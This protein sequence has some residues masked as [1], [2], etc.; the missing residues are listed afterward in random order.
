MWVGTNGGVS[1]Y[2]GANWTTFTTRQSLVNNG[3][4]AILQDHRGNFW[5]GTDNGVSRFDPPSTPG[6]AG[7][8]TTFNTH[9]GLVYNTVRTIIQDRDGTLWFGTYGGGVSRFDG[10]QW[11]SFTR[12]QDPAD[13]WTQ[14]IFQDQAGHLWFGS[15][16]GGVLRYDGQTLQTLIRADGL[17]GNGIKAIFQD[18]DGALWFGTGDGVTRYRPP[19]PASPPVLIEAV[20]A[21]D[22]YE[23][24][25]DVA[26]SSGAGLV[27]FEF[28]GISFKTRPEAMVYRYRLKGHDANWQT[29]RARRVEYRNL[30]RGG[31]V[32]EVQAVDRD[33]NYSAM[34]ASVNLQMHLP[35]ERIGWIAALAIALALVAW[36]TGRVIHR[37][38]RLS[39]ANHDLES[40]NQSLS[41]VN[42]DLSHVNQALEE[43]TFNLA[44]A[45]DDL[46]S[47][48]RQ[49]KE[50]DRL[51]SQFLANMSHELRTPMNAI[52]GFTRIVLRRSGD[53]LPERQKDN[54]DKVQQSAANLLS[55]INDILDL[56]KIEAG[57]LEIQPAP[58]DVQK[59]LTGCCASLSPLVKPDVD[60]TCEVAPDVGQAHTDEARVRQ[61]MT[62]LVNN[63]LKFTDTGQVR[64]RA[65]K[66]PARRSGDPDLLVLSV[67]DT[68]IGM[69][70]EALS[71]IFEEFR[72]VDGATTRRYGG[73]GLGLSIT[74]RLADLLGGDVD[75]ESQE[76]KGSTFT[77]R[78]PLVYQPS[79]DAPQISADTGDRPIRTPEP[80][81]TPQSGT[82]ADAPLIL[83]IDNDPDVAAL[84]RQELGEAG[85]R[86]VGVSSTLEGF[87]KA[88]DL[89]PFAIA[90][91]ILM[92]DKDSWAAI[93]LLKADPSTRDIP[94][95]IISVSDNKALAARLGVADYLVKPV[96][97]GSLLAAMGRLR[98]KDLRVIHIIDD[99]P[100]DCSLLQQLLEGEGYRVHIATGGRDGLDALQSECPDALLLDLMMPEMDGFAV[101]ERMYENTAWRDI[102]VI[103][104]TAKDLTPE[105]RTYLQQRTR[106]ILSK[107]GLDHTTL[108]QALQKAM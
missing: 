6:Q 20:A 8:W 103:V 94:I 46:E 63:A 78:L 92:P 45:N 102:P 62:N 1:R 2:N 7:H 42:E 91:N 49:I 50:A 61:I 105:E 58:F 67:E 75:V 93:S 27:A 72:Q 15:W 5:F 100:N 89:Q 9:N 65:T 52:I 51:K 31:Y 22:R 71:H 23:G 73:T 16:N 79:N 87:V 83:A 101:L 41:V 12:A 34:P 17:A 85:Y 106:G 11:Q 95:I 37:D 90:L 40:A 18:H 66:E 81:E 38:R 44:R 19:P 30:P 29:T 55:L 99:D 60:L 96:D 43:S 24:A 108:V 28:R 36:Q 97:R 47:A 4:N 3:V 76:G 86:V 57:R 77:V 13:D 104:V 74:Q 10:T 107:T 32:F 26:I 33:L 68:G 14:V 48:N 64:V 54:L 69:P 56:S 25:T 80:R 70:S 39:K 35:Y 88:R 21:D 98:S 84:L 82:D 53:I 59:M